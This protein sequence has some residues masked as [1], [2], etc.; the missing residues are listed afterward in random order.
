[1]IKN[2]YP[3]YKRNSLNSTVGDKKAIKKWARDL[4][5]HFSRDVQM[6]NKHKK[7]YSTSF[8]IKELHI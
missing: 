3:R 8:V 7:R 2:L 6:A 4:G 5:R 1:M